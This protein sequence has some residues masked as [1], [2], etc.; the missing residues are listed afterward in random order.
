MI[1]KAITRESL[2]SDKE[3]DIKYERMLELT[4]QIMI[5]KQIDLLLNDLERFSRISPNINK[6]KDIV[7]ETIKMESLLE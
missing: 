3:K 6:G 1:D 4:K 2:K 7:E 5:G